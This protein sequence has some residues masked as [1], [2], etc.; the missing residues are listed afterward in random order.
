M[1]PGA[2]SAGTSTI[3]AL[4]T[5]PG[6]SAIAVVRLSGPGVREALAALGAT[7]GRPRQAVLRPLRDADGEILDRALVLWFPAPRS[8]TGEDCAEL[9]LHGSRFVVQAVLQRLAQLG[10][11][12]AEPG[13]FTRRAFE[14]GK[15]DLAQ[16]EA[17]AD[18][19]DAETRAQARQALAQ[20]DGELSGRHA[21]WREALVEIRARLE[22]L[23]DFPDEDIDAGLDLA[24]RRMEAL[25][26]DLAQAGQDLGRGRAIREGWRV[27]II[28]AP[29]AGK[30]TLLNALAGRSAAIVTEIAGTTRDV[31]EVPIEL[32]GYRA[33]LADMAGLR[34]TDDPVEREG[35][36]RARAWAV[37]A[38]VRLWLVDRS[39][40][41]G[42]EAGS[43]LLKSG[44]L[45]V[46][47]KADRPASAAASG[48]A[49]L[50]CELGLQTLETTLRGDDAE[51]VRAWLTSTARKML[52]SQD[53]PA[54]TRIRHARALADARDALERA[55]VML[56]EPELA[57]ED[58]R[59]ASR[60]LS[61]ITGEVGAEDVLDKVFSSFCIGK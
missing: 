4:A 47:N 40:A 17:I 55:L 43:D 41:E 21:A 51:L 26:A 48:A 56:D 42:W 59:L 1:G 9:H 19:V 18:L 33:L 3:A 53:F 31:I 22:A 37:E 28:G 46:L 12:L 57:A 24:R 20:L 34:Q 11:R 10:V 61:R 35:V 7:P 60:A 13:E 8:Y 16:A 38:D 14:A 32:H 52:E 58:V 30:S 15:L 36:A 39:A 6:R 44:D 49:A 29:N 5:A 50:A 27:A 25:S 2:S 45:C 54:A 23:V